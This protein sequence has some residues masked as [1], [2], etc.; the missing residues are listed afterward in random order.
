MRMHK[1]KNDDF[2][3]VSETIDGD[4]KLAGAMWKIFQINT[5][6]FISWFI[7]LYADDEVL[8]NLY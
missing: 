1:S 2:D 3:F 5:R 4:E 7:T 8:A 6:I